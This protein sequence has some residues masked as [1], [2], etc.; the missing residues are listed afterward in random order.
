MAT[1]KAKSKNADSVEAHAWDVANPTATRT[2]LQGTL[3]VAAQELLLS[4]KKSEPALIIVQGDTVGRVIRLKAGRNVIGRHSDSDI[5]MQQRAVSSAHAEIRVSETS[6]ILEDLKS[7]NGTL[8]NKDKIQR[9]AVL[10]A[11]D[12]VKIGNWVFKYVDNKLDASLAESLH[13]QTTTD[14][15]TGVSN[16][17]YLTTALNSSVEV[18]KA[19][20]PLSVI[21]FDLD[22]FKKVNDTYGHVAG[23]F[24]LKEACRV[25]KDSVVRSDDVLGRF[26]GEEFMLIMP[27]SPLKIAT[28][29]AERIRKT[30]E[31]HQF[32]FNNTIIPV[33]ASLG[34]CS[35]TPAYNTATALLEAVDKLLYKSKQGGR[36]RVS[37]P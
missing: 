26:G 20:Y 9:P 15:L 32:N 13:L 12:L 28:G 36:N 37:A 19:G 17:A 8:L 31:Q 3:D 7:T 2:E 34:V 30:L 16:K 22:H 1:K 18:A 25:I 27:D 6:V 33:T 35:W 10:Q 14:A 23:D 11:G 21:I 24:V 5:P 29:V 4:A